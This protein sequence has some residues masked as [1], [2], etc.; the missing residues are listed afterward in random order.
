MR[1]SVYLMIFCFL[2][3]MLSAATAFGAQQVEDIDR[4]RANVRALDRVQN[5]I[6]QDIIVRQEAGTMSLQERN[7]LIIFS[8]YLQERNRDYCGRIKQQAGQGAVAD[9]PCPAQQAALPET[10]ARTMEEELAALDQ[11]LAQSLGDFDE[12]LLKEQERVAARQPRARESG[13]AG[14][15]GN[16]DGSDAAGTAGSQG[17]SGEGASGG[18]ASGQ[19]STSGQGRA[20]ASGTAAAGKPGQAGGQVG[21]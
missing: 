4:L 15:G 19:Q 1:F 13:G 14:G 9:L 11:S 6:A 21:T 2:S 8:R 5:N 17:E 3:S 12:M 10:T 16:G 18:G 20:P 7:E